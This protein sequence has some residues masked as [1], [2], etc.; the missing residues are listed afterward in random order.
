M[1]D[2]RRDAE[3]PLEPLDPLRGQRDLRQE[4]ERLPPLADALGDRVQI[5]LGLA[6]TGHA[7]QQR[8]REDA[9][10]D[11]RAQRRGRVPLLGRQRGAVVS[12]IRECEARTRGQLDRREQAR[13]RHR[14]DHAAPDPGR[15]RQPRG[16][17]RPAVRPARPA[18][19]AAHRS[20]S[21][22]GSAPPRATRRA[23]AAAAVPRPGAPCPLPRRAARACIRPPS[24]RSAAASRA[25]AVC[26]GPR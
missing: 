6:R 23:R 2:R 13:I 1:P 22:R 9:G 26:P 18:P 11:G 17:P 25:S 4:H 3:P 16:A 8:D 12:R 14:P 15:P 24:P 5:D 21:H 7:V 19:A 20:V 10:G